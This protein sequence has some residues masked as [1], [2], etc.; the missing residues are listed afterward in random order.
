MCQTEL[1]P[2]ETTIQL[3]QL[4]FDE[5]DAVFDRHDEPC[6]PDDLVQLKYLDCCIKET[7]RLYPSIPAIIRTIS[8]DVKIGTKFIHMC[9]FILAILYY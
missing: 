3:Q 9:L 4:L 7:L 2:A 6:M 1:R 8:E 5:V